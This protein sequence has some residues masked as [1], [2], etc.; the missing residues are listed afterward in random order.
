MT[1]RFQILTILGS[2][3]SG[4][5]NTRALVDNFVEDVATEGLPLDH[6]VIALGQKKV[7]P[8]KGCWNCTN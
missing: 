1:K 3:H 6:Q 2:P 4:N 8:C 5:S 7:L